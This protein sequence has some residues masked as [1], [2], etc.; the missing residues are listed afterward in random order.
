[1]SGFVI[2]RER[3]TVL[4]NG[5]LSLQSVKNKNFAVVIFIYC[6]QMSCDSNRWS[7][8]IELKCSI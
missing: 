5:T 4:L 6:I 3:A 1:M 2:I 7:L 8:K